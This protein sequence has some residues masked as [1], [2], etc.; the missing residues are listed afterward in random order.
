MEFQ[1]RSDQP[2]ILT[3]GDECLRLYPYEIWCQFEAKIVETAE[4]DPDAES[5]VRLM[6]TSADDCPI[7]KQGRILVPQRL[8]EHARLEKEAVVAG[9][10]RYVE[11]WDRS[12]YEADVMRAKAQ[13]KQ[14]RRSL[15]PKLGH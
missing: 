6:L 13:V 14:L 4:I 9:M 11:I 2:P 1:R 3:T 8:R 12:L 10:G 7:D 15:A 5:F